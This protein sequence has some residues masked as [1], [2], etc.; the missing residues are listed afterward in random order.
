MVLFG[1]VRNE[2]HGGRLADDTWEWDGAQWEQRT[3]A[4]SPSGRYFHAMTYDPVRSRTVLFGGT[5][6]VRQPLQL[7][8]ETWE[9][10]GEDWTQLTLTTSPP[11]R[12][13]HALAHDMRRRGVVVFGGAVAQDVGASDTWILEP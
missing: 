2:P 4:H 8:N 6:D 7:S 3:P 10:D 9:W 12:C 13:L 5:A 11:A 1:G